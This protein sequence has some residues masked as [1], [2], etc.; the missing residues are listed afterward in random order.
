MF[1]S[2]SFLN[3]NSGGGKPSGG[4]GT[5]LFSI[6]GTGLCF[7]FSPKID[8]NLFSCSIDNTFFIRTK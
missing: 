6:V 7:L 5:R 1:G 8:L 4:G 3:Y 2:T